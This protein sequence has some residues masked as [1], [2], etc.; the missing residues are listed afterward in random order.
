[1]YT[2]YFWICPATCIDLYWLDIY[3]YIYLYAWG[4]WCRGCCHH[5]GHVQFL[6]ASNLDVEFFIFGE[7]VGNYE[8][9][10]VNYMWTSTNAKNETFP[11]WMSLIDVGFPF[12]GSLYLVSSDVCGLEEFLAELELL[13]EASWQLQL[14][15]RND[16]CLTKRSHDNLWPWWFGILQEIPALQTTRTMNSPQ[17]SYMKLRHFLPKWWCPP[18]FWSS[19]ELCLPA[20]GQGLTWNRGDVSSSWSCHSA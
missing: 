19:Q 4:S 11:F 13:M 16:S 3:I 20:T 8:C 14:L 5:V 6:K 2:W 18:L 1:M 17:V 12:F 9:F 10:K 7:G 15:S